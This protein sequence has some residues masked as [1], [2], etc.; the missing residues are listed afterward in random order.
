MRE[1][2]ITCAI[3]GG[4]PSAHEAH[5]RFPVTPSEIALAAREAALE[6]ASIV[7]VHARDPRGGQPSNAFELFKEIAREIRSLGLDLLLNLSCSMDGQ[8]FF[9]DAA[10]PRLDPRTTLSPA[11]GR[12]RHAVELRPEIA[13]IDCGTVG[14]GESVFVARRSDLENMARLYRDAGVKPEV[15]CFDLGHMENARSLA[16]AGFF[17]PPPFVQICLGTAYGGAPATGEAFDA[18]LSRVPEGAVW[19]AFEA[20]EGYAR[21]MRRAISAGGHVRVGLE[22]TLFHADG[23][24]ADNAALVAEAANAI[25]EAGCRVADARAARNILGIG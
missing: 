20:G 5:P 7:H 24:A 15:E 2:I 3:N 19:A 1:V 13:T 4:S 22:D 12:V 18:M 6:G 9:D 25:R 11:A 17:A 14:V 10:L 21:T 23:G 8:V 16:S